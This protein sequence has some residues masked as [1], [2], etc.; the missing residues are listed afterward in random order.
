MSKR[1][2]VKFDVVILQGSAV[3]HWTLERRQ[4]SPET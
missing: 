3:S 4:Q 1:R 2:K